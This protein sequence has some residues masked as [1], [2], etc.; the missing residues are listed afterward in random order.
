M[1]SST[2]G[3]AEFIRLNLDRPKCSTVWRRRGGGGGGRARRSKTLYKLRCKWEQLKRDT[4]TQNQ[5]KLLET[6]SLIIINYAF[7]RVG[8]WV[9]PFSRRKNWWV[10]MAC[11]SVWK[12]HKTVRLGSIRTSWQNHNCP[13][14]NPRTN[15]VVT[16]F[17]ASV[18]SA[19]TWFESSNCVVGRQQACLKNSALFCNMWIAKLVI[20][21]GDVTAPHRIRFII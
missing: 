19:L 16:I 13:W 3:S 17:V 1:I 10:Y 21:R 5:L 9:K 7:W 18:A 6:T 14:Q 4:V 2:F 8:T 15:F 20:V 11:R 12:R